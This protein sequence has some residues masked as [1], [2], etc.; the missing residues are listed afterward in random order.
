M[1]Q[2]IRAF[3]GPGAFSAV[4]A[5]VLVA[6]FEEAGEARVLLTRRS[7]RLRRHT[8]EVAFPGGRLDEGEDA[9]AAALR[10]AREEVGLD[11]G[12]VE[13]L[14]QLT[15]RPT[16]SSTVRVVPVLSALRARPE[17][18]TST[19]EVER[20]FDVALSELMAA[21]VYREERWDRAD[22]VDH[23]MHF[24][25]L[26]DELVWGVTARILYEVLSLVHGSGRPSA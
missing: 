11:P 17:L 4:D 2:A 10:E 6:L 13:V 3:P 14:A 23:P 15:P 1:R 5:A 21:G 8:G 12:S 16:A 24:F 7:S 9:V 19:A 25:D 26:G 20:A 22:D 18:H